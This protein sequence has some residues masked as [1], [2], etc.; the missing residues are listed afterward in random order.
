MI[1]IRALG[2]SDKGSQTSSR[3]RSRFEQPKE[4]IARCRTETDGLGRT[5]VRDGFRSEFS[6]NSNPGKLGH[7]MIAVL[8]LVKAIVSRGAPEVWIARSDQNPPGLH[9]LPATPRSIRFN[10]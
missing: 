3:F 9:S 8:V 2:Q 4:A 7:E 6:C 1:K 10:G 5:V